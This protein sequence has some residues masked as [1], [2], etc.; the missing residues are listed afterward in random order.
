MAE[1]FRWRPVSSGGFQ[2]RTT[3]DVVYGDYVIPAGTAISGNHWAIH[4]DEGYYGPEVEEFNLDRWLAGGQFK[5]SMKNY[6][7]G[8]GRRVCPGQHVALNSVMIN[9]ALLLWAFDIKKQRDKDGREVEIDTLAF[10]S[11][12]NSHPLP[13]QAAFT[14][15][16]PGVREILQQESAMVA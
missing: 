16:I 13:F 1:S 6:Q 4:R 10:T 14:P 5:T 12:A 9:A 7:F 2:H 8:F 3:A 15:R 11:T